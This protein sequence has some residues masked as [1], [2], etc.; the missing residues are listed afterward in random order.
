[1]ISFLF[2][3]SLL[4]SAFASTTEPP[5]IVGANG[6]TNE[7][8]LTIT[9]LSA[10]NNFVEILVEKNNAVYEA[11][12]YF[13]GSWMNKGLS[14]YCK[15]GGDVYT[16]TAYKIVSAA[17]HLSGAIKLAIEGDMNGSMKNILS[18]AVDIWSMSKVDDMAFMLTPLN[19]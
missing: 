15:F 6:E 2:L 1:M 7:Q 19:Q 5:M 14:L 9:V 10:S 13:N 18:T 8:Q 11:C 4:V 12:N 16:C 17:C 3:C